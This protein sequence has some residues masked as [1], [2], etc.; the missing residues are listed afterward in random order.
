MINLGGTTCTLYAD[1]SRGTSQIYPGDV[2][3]LGYQ[4]DPVS[5]PL[6]LRRVVDGLAG[7]ITGE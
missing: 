1:V 6:T 3:T 2:I 4:W 7:S 5:M